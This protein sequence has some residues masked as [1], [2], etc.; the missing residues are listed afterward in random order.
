MRTMEC[1]SGLMIYQNTYRSEDDIFNIG[2]VFSDVFL[3]LS[4]QPSLFS[5]SKA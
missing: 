3:K 1:E 2:G 5:K 4:L